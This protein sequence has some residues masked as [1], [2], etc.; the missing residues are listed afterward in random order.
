[1][2]TAE[3]ASVIFR[4]LSPVFALIG[5]GLFLLGAFLVMLGEEDGFRLLLAG[6][7]AVAPWLFGPSVPIDGSL[8]EGPKLGSFLFLYFSVPVFF[9]ASA[10]ALVIS[11][12]RS[13]W[14]RNLIRKL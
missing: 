6:V 10:I 12:V 11:F 1:M 13:A 5:A 2:I 8:F 14:A 4:D 7:I 9:W 3:I